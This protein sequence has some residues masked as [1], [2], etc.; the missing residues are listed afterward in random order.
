MS[1]YIY[2]S[3]ENCVKRLRQLG[4]EID[5]ATE[6]DL[7][8]QARVHHL[9]D[10]QMKRVVL[11]CREYYCEK[12]HGTTTVIRR[13]QRKRKTQGYISSCPECGARFTGSWKVNWFKHK[14]GSYTDHRTDMEKISGHANLEL[15]ESQ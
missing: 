4:C 5:A 10:V 15:G 13:P 2:G 1:I 3:V 14:D 11:E 12:G 9:L 8:T 6:R 7:I